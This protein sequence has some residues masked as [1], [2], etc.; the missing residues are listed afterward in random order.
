MTFVK[1][2]TISHTVTLLITS[3]A[4][5]ETASA[6]LRIFCYIL[7]SRPYLVY[8]RAY[9]TDLRLSVCRLSVCTECIVA[10]RCVLERAKA[11]ID[12]L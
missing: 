5:F 2:L 10:K 4:E 9:V 8:G 1:Q 3:T 6:R 12:S 11:I 7:F